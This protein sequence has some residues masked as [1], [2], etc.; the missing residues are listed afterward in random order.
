MSRY[1]ARVTHCTDPNCV[2]VDCQSTYTPDVAIVEPSECIPH[3]LVEHLIGVQSQQVGSLVYFSLDDLER[4]VVQ[5]RG[6]D[7]PNQATVSPYQQQQQQNVAGLPDVE[8]YQPNATPTVNNHYT[9]TN[10]GVSDGRNST[11]VQQYNTNQNAYPSS[12][13]G[14][15]GTRYVLCDTTTSNYSYNGSVS[16]GVTKGDVAK[17]QQRTT[18]RTTKKSTGVDK[19]ATT[20]NTREEVVSNQSCTA[21]CFCY[22]CKMEEI[23]SRERQARNIPVVVVE[24]KRQPR[25]KPDK[26]TKTERK[27]KPAKQYKPL[28]TERNPVVY[29]RTPDGI[30]PSV[31]SPMKPYVGYKSRYSTT[32]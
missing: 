28:P 16:G 17:Q 1:N 20:I 19:T 8:E 14:T 18:R 10:V 25:V 9:T 12:Y 22:R 32:K 27:S 15:S 6:I 30:T 23:A 24:G 21:G 7:A 11:P 31:M 4:S 2:V 5:P 13:G 26:P 29:E 3:D